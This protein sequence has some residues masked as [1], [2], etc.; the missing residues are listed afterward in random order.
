M[1]RALAIDEARFGQDDPKVARH[2]SNLAGLLRATNSLAEAEPLMRRALASDEASFGNEHPNVARGLNTLALLLKDANR[3]TEAEP[4]MR[5]TVVIILQFTRETSHQH[6][7]LMDTIKN[8][9]RLLQKM[10]DTETQAREKI[11]ILG[12]TYGISLQSLIS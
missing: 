3:L 11:S 8:Y 9:Y 12:E 5:R 4:L 6:P 10:G 7:H 2:L 1:R